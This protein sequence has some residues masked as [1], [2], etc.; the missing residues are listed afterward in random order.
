MGISQ[1]LLHFSLSTSEPRKVDLINLEN[2]YGFL[3]GSNTDSSASG[4]G[5]PIIAIVTN[6]DNFGITPV[7]KVL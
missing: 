3:E 4:S 7:Y 5:N 1:N 2:F 6:Y